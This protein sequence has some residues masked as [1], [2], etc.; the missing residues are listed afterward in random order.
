MI[1][2]QFNPSSRTWFIRR[3]GQTQPS[4][5]RQVVGLFEVARRAYWRWRMSEHKP[6]R[7][8]D[9]RD[10]DPHRETFRKEMK[11]A[12][13]DIMEGRD[14]G[15]HVADALGAGREG[16]DFATSLRAKMLLTKEGLDAK[17]DEEAQ[18]MRDELRKRIGVE[19]F[20]VLEAHDD[21]L[22]RWVAIAPTLD[23]M[24][25]SNLGERAKEFG[26]AFQNVNRRQQRLQGMRKFMNSIKDP[27]KRDEFYVRHQAELDELTDLTALEN[28]PRLVMKDEFRDPVEKRRELDAAYRRLKEAGSR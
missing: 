14:P 26:P 7:F 15:L 10:P 18:A 12:Y 4:S 6:S 28:E 25:P 2:V 11:L 22:G 5:A 27:V 1:Q 19:A 3:D 17:T 8:Q 13:Q 9:N 21:M 24:G 16:K 23:T 20:G